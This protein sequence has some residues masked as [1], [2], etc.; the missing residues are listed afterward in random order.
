MTVILKKEIWKDIPGYEGLYQ[1]ST[2]GRIKRLP[3]MKISRRKYDYDKYCLTEEKI[4]NLKKTPWAG[5]LCISLSKNKKSKNYGVHQLIL[6]TFKGPCP[7]GMEACHNNGIPWD[8][9]SINLRW[10]THKNNYLD[11]VKHSNIDNLTR[12]QLLIVRDLLML[13]KYTH[14]QISEMTKIK[15]Q[16]VAKIERNIFNIYYFGIKNYNESKY[17]NH[18]NSRKLLP[19]EDFYHLSSH[20][21]FF[22]KH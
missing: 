7:L 5:H 17:K 15:F 13:C 21:N 19:L 20:P 9:R 14:L 12:E 4:F 22:K 2:F 6:F 10:D 18:K 1:A 3:Y 11:Y 8:N 16:K